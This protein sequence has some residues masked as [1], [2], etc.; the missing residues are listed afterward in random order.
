MAT[1]TR[2]KRSEGGEDRAIQARAQQP[3]GLSRLGTPGLQ[4]WLPLESQ[5]QIFPFLTHSA[6][7]TKAAQCLPVCLQ[8]VP[9]SLSVLAG[10][11]DEHT[12]KGKTTSTQLHSQA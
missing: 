3:N 4:P 7:V 5:L 6:L 8:T 10:P 12:K 11:V 1:E 9:R 2:S